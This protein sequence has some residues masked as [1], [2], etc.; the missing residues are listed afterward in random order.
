MMEDKMMEDKTQMGN[1]TQGM[2]DKTQ[3]PNLVA[4][5]TAR[6]EAS[7]S[8]LSQDQLVDLFIDE[9]IKEKGIE[10]SELEKNRIA[11]R[12]KDEVL[13]EILMRMPNYLVDKINDSLD[14][15]TASDR[16]FDD[17]I[18]E[19]GIDASKIAESAM[20]KFRED[21]LSD[22]LGEEAQ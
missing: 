3:N 1:S 20:L 22:K 16:L 13:T 9:L 18:E 15:G 7:L 4:L 14:N 11:E 6:D 10:V 2:G 21:F 12:L 19:S 8:G 17:A 5:G